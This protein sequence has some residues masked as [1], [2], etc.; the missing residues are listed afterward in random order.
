LV[1]VIPFDNDSVVQG[2]SD[3]ERKR[4]GLV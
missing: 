3:L 1:T 2:V 4:R